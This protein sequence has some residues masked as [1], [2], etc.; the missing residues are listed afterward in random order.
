M[1]LLS[2][3][4]LSTDIYISKWDESY[5][6]K[7]NYLFYPKEEV[8]KFLNRF[9]RKKIGF[10]QFIDLIDFSKT[11]RALDLGCGIG[12][13]TFL[14]NEFGLESYGVDISKTAIQTAKDTAKNLGHEDFTSRLSTINGAQL[15]FNNAYFDV[16]I[17]DS[18]LDSMHF[19]V[20]RTLINE[21]DRVAKKLVF[22]SFIAPNGLRH[23]EEFSGEEVVSSEHE[24]GTIQS[25]FTLSKIQ[26]LIEKTK[27]NIAWCHL[28][29]DESILT[30]EKNCRFYVVLKK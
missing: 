7:E 21:I 2:S 27:F 9:V 3:E 15:P 6:R 11:V 24:Q 22:L 14:M 29:T 12:R 26:A 25:Y 5:N 30:K 1:D 20:A 4:Q 23:N 16:V 10:N 28:V 18:V 8:V 17:C 19:E 13:Q